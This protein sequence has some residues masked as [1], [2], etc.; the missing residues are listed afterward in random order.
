MKIRI[1]KLEED[2]QKSKEQRK[3]DELIISALRKRLRRAE[4][5]VGVLQEK[6]KWCEEVRFDYIKKGDQLKKK[7]MKL[8]RT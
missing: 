8:Q 4:N 2:L 1:E 6:L 3:L 5:E 7:A